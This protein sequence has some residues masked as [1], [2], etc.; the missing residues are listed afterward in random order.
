MLD[1]QD[2]ITIQQEELVMRYVN[3]RG[4]IKWENVANS[5]GKTATRILG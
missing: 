3:S 2:F 5:G 4:S 1:K